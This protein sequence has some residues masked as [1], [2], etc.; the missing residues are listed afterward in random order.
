[1]QIRASSLADLEGVHRML[2][3]LVKARRLLPRDNEELERLLPTGFVAEADGEIIGFAAVEIYS[4]KLAEIQALGVALPWRG[5]GLGKAL[6][7]HCIRLAHQHGVYE[8]MAITASDSLFRDCG[9]DYSLPD[10][11]KALFIQLYHKH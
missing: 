6:V 3:P 2:D 7:L 8:L 5:Q 11:K 10:Q 1:V 4:K 9:F